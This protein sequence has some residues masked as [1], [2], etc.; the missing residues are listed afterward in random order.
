MAYDHEHEAEEA[1]GYALLLM[2]DPNKWKLEV[3]E[4]LGW[5]FCLKNGPVSV[6]QHKDGYSCLIASNVN[7]P[8]GGGPWT[9]GTSVFQK[10]PMGAV[11]RASADFRRYV[12]NERL[13]FVQLESSLDVG[14]PLFIE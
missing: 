13:R 5:Y 4:N 7:D 14:C 10:T 3:W 12:L 11:R 6:Y 2:S 9:R 1:G 8:H